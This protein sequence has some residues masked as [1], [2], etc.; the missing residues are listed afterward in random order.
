MKE[1]DYQHEGIIE[2]KK[3]IFS[4]DMKKVGNQVYLELS[5]QHVGKEKLICSKALCEI[6]ANKLDGL[7]KIKVT[8]LV[9][10]KCVNALREKGYN[11]MSSAKGYYFGN[12]YEDYL[13][14]ARQVARQSGATLNTF[15]NVVKMM[16]KKFGEQSVPGDLQDFLDWIY[17]Q[18]KEEED[19]DEID[20]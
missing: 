11:V 10:W 14:T 17:E 15:K 5:R 18:E 2:V 20:Y 8:P 19:N 3:T 13:V 4:K 1:N 7:V 16:K 6:I 9:V 12:S